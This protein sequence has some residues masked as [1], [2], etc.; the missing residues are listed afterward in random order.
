[1]TKPCTL[2]STP[3]QVLVRCTIDESQ[4]WHFV[5]P[6]ACWKK[7]SGGVEDAKG[8]EE[9]FPYYRY[10]G[11]WKDRH[12]DGPMSA[13]KPRKVK[14]RQRE[15][16]R[17]RNEEG[18]S[19]RVSDGNRSGGEGGCADTTGANNG[20]GQALETIRHPDTAYSANG[21]G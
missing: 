14:E 16:L 13:K 21:T 15:E 5:C 7:V 1:M 10:G 8:L 9:R 4:K 11:M 3:R 6:G 12:A 19:S 18:G 2:C 17:S 20:I